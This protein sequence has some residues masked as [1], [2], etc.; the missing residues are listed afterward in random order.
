MYKPCFK[1]KN[2]VFKFF[3]FLCCPKFLVKLVIEY[4]MSPHLV[5]LKVRMIKA[6]VLDADLFI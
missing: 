6:F 2:G 1:K 4:D 3:S 5:L